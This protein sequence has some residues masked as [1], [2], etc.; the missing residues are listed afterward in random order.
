MALLLQHLG[1]QES[2]PPSRLRRD[3]GRPPASPKICRCRLRPH[4]VR[5]PV[6]HPRLQRKSLLLF[7]AAPLSRVG[8]PLDSSNVQFLRGVEP[9]RRSDVDWK[10]ALPSIP[11]SSTYWGARIRTWSL[12]VQSQM[13][14]PCTTPQSVYNSL[15]PPGDSAVQIRAP[16]Y[17]DTH[18]SMVGIPGIVAVGLWAM[19]FPINTYGSG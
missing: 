11:S 8:A 13:C 4:F 9:I 16:T 14:Y 18:Q 1:S 6:G 10:S 2:A 12:L 19:V 5:A 7:V 17:L 15:D 3:S